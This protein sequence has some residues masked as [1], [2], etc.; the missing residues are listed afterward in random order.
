[1]WAGSRIRFLRAVPVGAE[2]TRL[3]TI[4]DIANK[5]TG[6]GQM[7]LVTVE[8]RIL[9]EDQ[10]AIV[11][12]QDVAYLQERTGATQGSRPALEM[13]EP[14]AV[15]RLQATPEL[16]FR[17]SALT[18]N[19][20]R[21]HYDRDYARHEENYPGLVVHGPLLAMLLVDHFL[22]GRKAERIQEF[23]VRARDPVFDHEAFELCSAPDSSGAALWVSDAN[24]GVRMTAEI[25]IER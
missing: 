16:L 7:L 4:T 22:R 11:E 12:L 9:F 5:V 18:F 19:A 2:L 23:S 20:H 21:I 25:R 15:R 1:M 24:G 6:S 17:F 14:E 3:S 10:A 8:H 13:P